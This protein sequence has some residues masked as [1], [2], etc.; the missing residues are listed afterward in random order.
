MEKL[1]L[2]FR[3]MDNL[4]LTVR[5]HIASLDVVTVGFRIEC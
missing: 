2:L 3:G 4:V 1:T 5:E